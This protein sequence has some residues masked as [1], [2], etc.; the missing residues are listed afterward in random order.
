MKSGVCPSYTLC[1]RQHPG[2]HCAIT[3]KARN[4]PDIPKCI[5]QY[6]RIL[7]QGSCLLLSPRMGAR[8]CYG[9]R[10]RHLCKSRPFRKQLPASAELP[11][12]SASYDDYIL[13][14]DRHVCLC[15]PALRDIL[16][17]GATTQSWVVVWK[18]GYMYKVWGQLSSFVLSR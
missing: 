3:T 16:P 12:P 7:T 14:Y 8:I 10:L 4:R 13:G 15:R 18:F 11:R 1:Q 2:F 5:K 17:M 9:R 6:L